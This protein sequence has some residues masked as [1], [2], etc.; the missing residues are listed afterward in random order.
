MNNATVIKVEGS[1]TW[2]GEWH[3]SSR[4]G[5]N[6]QMEWHRNGNVNTQ[7]INESIINRLSATHDVTV[8]K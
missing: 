1:A 5:P 2:G 8:I 3:K 7:P 4:R 6:G